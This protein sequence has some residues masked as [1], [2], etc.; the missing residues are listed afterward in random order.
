MLVR[1]WGSR[2]SIPAS[3]NA[4]G[5]REKV[6]AA[7]GFAN[8]RTFGSQ[9]EIERFV[10]DALP[11]SVRGTYG[12][13]SPCVQI[14]S[15]HD[16]ESLL[17]DLGTGVRE[18][19]AAMLARYG[20]A[21]R[22]YNVLM[23]HLH[24]DHIMGFPFFAPAYIKGNVIRIHGANG[25]LRAAFERQHGGP[26][27]PVPF[28]GLGAQIEFVTLVP[29]VEYAVGGFSVRA[30][31]QAHTGD[32]FGY[33][34]ER[35]GKTVVYATDSEHKLQNAGSAAPYVEFFRDADV[36]I[37]DA[38]YSLADAVTLREDWGHSTN[39]VGVELSH[40]AGV[41]HLVLFHHEPANG[42]A[43]IDAILSETRR[44]ET[45]TRTGA[46]L[47]ITAA[48]DGLGISV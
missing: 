7:I 15:E 21:P 35:D 10:A 19:G 13:N 23:S 32:S 27:F 11:F 37:F 41:R 3:L 38:M 9:E 34:I 4:A 33:R 47:L 26:S 43:A 6:V 24:W 42:D 20:A 5:V 46:P 44:Y 45:I 1:F 14:D 36:L 22:T 16:G 18:F 12:G 25:Q 2:G 48:Y 39:I 17:C 30:M 31:L 29:G 40:L 8:G 28:D